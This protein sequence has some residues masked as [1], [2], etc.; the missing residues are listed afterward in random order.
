M[1]ILNSLER[2]PDAGN[3]TAT[4]GLSILI[5]LLSPIVPHITHRLW[6]EL[7]FGEDVMQAAWPEVDASA[8]EQDSIDYVVQV[9]GKTRGNVTVPKAA[10]Q[11]ATE[12][13]VKSLDL[14]KRN[15]GDKAIKRIIIV[16]G[17]LINVVA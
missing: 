7:G 2:L 8:L 6:R 4:E 13:I 1:K 17:R 16:P 9:N 12:E 10:D 14:V 5:R 3:A 15:V 11:R